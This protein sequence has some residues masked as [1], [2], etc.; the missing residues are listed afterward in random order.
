MFACVIARWIA[1][2]SCSRNVQIRNGIHNRA[3]EWPMLLIQAENDRLAFDIALCWTAGSTLLENQNRHMA[4]AMAMHPRLGNN[5]EANQLVTDIVRQISLSSIS[6]TTPNAIYNEFLHAHQVQ[7]PAGEHHQLQSFTYSGVQTHVQRDNICCDV[8]RMLRSEN[9]RQAAYVW[10]VRKEYFFCRRGW[11]AGVHPRYVPE[12]IDMHSN[13][14]VSGIFEG[15]PHIYCDT[16]FPMCWPFDRC[17]H[18][19]HITLASTSAPWTIAQH[20]NT[21]QNING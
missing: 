19:L 9:S 15:I 4:I 3:S 5:S 13:V 12:P 2:A 8:R 1:L 11:F 17:I 7:S 16:W 10:P 20:T 18:L 14:I 6:A 21:D